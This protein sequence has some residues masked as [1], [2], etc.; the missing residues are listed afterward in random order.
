MDPT[1]GNGDYLI[2]DQ[3]SYKFESPHRGDVIIFRYPKDTTK[4]FIKRVIG[5]PN[6]TV[7]IH[8]GVIVIKN[9]DYPDGFTL[10]EPYISSQNKKVDNLPSTK[11]KDDEY[12]VLGDN[13]AGS[14]D[15]RSWGTVSK[16]LIAGKPVIRIL[17]LGRLGLLPGEIKFGQ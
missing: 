1:F 11:I 4:F 2:T 7:E 12:F 3:I 8:S 5:L 15:S 16:D 10:S 14:L 17:P 9:S 6:E 13:R